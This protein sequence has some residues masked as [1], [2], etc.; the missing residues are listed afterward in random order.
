M[1]Y[2]P[3]SHQLP[4][5]D[6]VIAEN[7]ERA[8]TPQRFFPDDL[9]AEVDDNGKATRVGRVGYADAT[10]VV[11]SWRSDLVT[12]GLYSQDNPRFVLHDRVG[13]SQ[14]VESHG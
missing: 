9:V 4:G 1:S 7:M 10:S 5:C 14:W 3:A 12:S 11:I 8:L 13:P 2:T 6:D